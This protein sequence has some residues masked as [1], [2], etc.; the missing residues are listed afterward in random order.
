MN[1]E[2]LKNIINKYNKDGSFPTTIS[3]DFNLIDIVDD[4]KERYF[5]KYLE[6]F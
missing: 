6:S 4:F 1:F 5:E 3:L 2:E